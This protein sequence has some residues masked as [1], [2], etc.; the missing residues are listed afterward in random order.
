[1]TAGAGEDQEVLDPLELE[2]QAVLSY[3]LWVLGIKIRSS[4]RAACVLNS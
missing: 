3:P 2:L 1:M 4:G